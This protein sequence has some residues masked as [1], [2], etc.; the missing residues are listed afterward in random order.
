M[1]KRWRLCGLC[2]AVLLL[3]VGSGRA[4]VGLPSGWQG[5]FTELA[6][7]TDP[8]ARVVKIS[9]KFLGTPY[10]ARTL[11]GGADIPEQLVAEFG[12]VDCFTLLDYVEALRRSATPDDFPARLVE[13]RYRDGII[14]WD[15]RRHFFTDWA[16]APDGRIVDV[17][18][19]VGG[20][21]TR[22]AIKQLNRSA[23]GTRLLAG[24]E[25]RER[26]VSL[27]P[28][29]ALDASVSSR[30]RS[31]DYL[32]IYAPEEGLDVSHVGIVI[33]R[34]DHLYLRHASSRRESGRVIDSDL[35]AYLA[36]KSGIVIL[37]PR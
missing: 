12:G 18:V 9:E 22:R 6:A 20:N 3:A 30:L 15:H 37:R 4:E 5:V 34:D 33:R 32:G 7:S 24:V 26:P 21:Q 14:A 36:G 16:A 28:P 29:Q 19:E 13:V 10:R 27:I 25:V 1:N 11:I 31:G 17:T 35:A 8:G 2:L 23:A